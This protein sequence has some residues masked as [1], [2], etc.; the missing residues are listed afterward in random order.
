MLENI[1]LNA[2]EIQELVERFLRY[3]R[4]DTQSNEASSTVP[5]TPG[6]RRL[7]GVLAA[8]LRELGAAE[9]ALSDYS[10]VFATLPAT[11]DV[12]APTVAFLAH[13][14]TAADFSGA[15]VKP[16]LHRNYDGRPIVL[17]DDPTQVLR[18]E[19]NPQL[20]G[21]IGEDLITAS[22][23]TLL[24]AD[25]KAGVAILMTLAAKLLRHPEIPHG[26]L[27]ICFTPDEEIGRGVEHLTP[28]DL[29]ADVAYTLDGGEAGEITYE[30]FS[31]DKAIVTITG[32]AVH[33]GVA[34]GKLVNA[35]RLAGR[36]LN[37]LPAEL[38][39][40]MTEG[41]EGYIHPYRIQGTA[42]EVTLGFTLRDFE[43]E[44]LQAHGERLREI[45]R[46][47]EAEEPRARITCVITP[48]YRN[49]RYGLEKDLRPVELA[50]EAL[51][52]LGIAPLIRPIRG[53]TDGAGLTAKGVPT[54]NLFTGMFNSHGPLEWIS[55]QD[56]ARSVQ[57]CLN[58]ARLWARPRETS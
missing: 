7:L 52:P 13:V 8:E 12:A 5:S 58:L 22:G 39:P 4:Y 46:T 55:V 24:G 35:L 25:D 54:P 38:S 2:T 36:F 44:Q 15:N 14:D 53:G 57:L 34:K 29:R 33:P 23:T 43:L 56:M 16:L 26:P 49:M 51:R 28:E 32:I 45:A 21:K 50:L 17:P 41:R 6:Q 37:A 18:P 48:Q 3:V 40:E 20:A 11:E 31:A 10:C 47:L 42:A 1:P 27:R 30:T 9:V 19:E